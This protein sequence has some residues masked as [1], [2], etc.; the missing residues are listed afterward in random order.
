[1]KL[2]WF[3]RSLLW[4]QSVQLCRITNVKSNVVRSAEKFTQTC[5]F[6]YHTRANCTNGSDSARCRN[7]QILTVSQL[8]AEK[9]GRHRDGNLCHLATHKHVSSLHRCQ[10]CIK[11]TTNQ[12]RHN[13]SHSRRHYIILRQ[14][15][16]NPLF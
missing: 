14:V 9:Q 8:N 13:I 7:V 4:H 3:L 11:T 1:M 16:D 10:H 15:L 5:Q 6:N 2:V 12:T